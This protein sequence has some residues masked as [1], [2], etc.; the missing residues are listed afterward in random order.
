MAYLAEALLGAGRNTEALQVARGATEEARAAE[1][2]SFE[3]HAQ[4][5]LAR[6][7][8]STQGAASEPEASAALDVAQ[9]RLEESGARSYSPMLLEERAR[10]ASA[11]SGSAAADTLRRDA[12]REYVELGAAG[13]AERLSLQFDL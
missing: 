9:A 1:G 2:L 12:H 8:I 6:V 10:L 3:L 13:H 11:L 7:L 5:A 4:L